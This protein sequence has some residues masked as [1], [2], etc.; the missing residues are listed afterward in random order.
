MGY[1]TGSDTAPAL[2]DRLRL[3]KEFIAG[4][5]PDDKHIVKRCVIHDR[6]TIANCV[7]MLRE[8]T[9][10]VWHDGG[11]F[12][13]GCRGASSMQIV[14]VGKDG[15]PSVH[16]LVDDCGQPGDIVLI[17]DGVRIR[18]LK[19]TAVVFLGW[20]LLTAA[21]D[22]GIVF[23]QD[24]VFQAIIDSMAAKEWQATEKHEV[25]KLEGEEEE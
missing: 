19:N 16:I 17:R 13:S 23:K 25:K 21:Y 14:L 8:W 9:S 7:G 20:T 3:V 6:E 24:P 1:A 18:Y 12:K 4:K 22:K 2:S 10:A 5:I 15:I 11:E